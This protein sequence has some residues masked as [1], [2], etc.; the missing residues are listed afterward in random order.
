MQYKEPDVQKEAE[1]MIE[2]VI[3]AKSAALKF[4]GC[5]PDYVRDVCHG[6]CCRYI[7]DKTMP[8]GR[9][10]MSIYTEP[11]QRKPLRE[12]GAKIGSNGILI[13]EKDGLCTFQSKSGLCTLHEA[14]T[15]EGEPVKPRS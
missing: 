13:P 6:R 9:R 4:Q 12:R 2:I 1:A 5:T 10:A 8:G 11:D 3:S 15:P 7:G 14:H